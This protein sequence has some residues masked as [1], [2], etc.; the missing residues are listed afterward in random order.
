MKKIV[1]FHINAVFL[2]VDGTLNPKLPSSFHFYQSDN[3]SVVNLVADYL[4]VVFIIIKIPCEHF[5]SSACSYT[6]AIW[7]GG[8]GGQKVLISKTF[9]L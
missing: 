2:S 5:I 7:G 8:R 3:K 9:L 6:C 4:A 1:F